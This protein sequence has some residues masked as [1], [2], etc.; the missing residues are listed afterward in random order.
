MSRNRF[1]KWLVAY[2]I[3]QFGVP[4]EESRDGQGRWLRYRNKHELEEQQS[5][6]I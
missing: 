3:Y 1:Y 4:P 5:L 6:E 2:G